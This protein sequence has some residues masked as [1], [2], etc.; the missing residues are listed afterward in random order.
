[1]QGQMNRS[2]NGVSNDRVE[3]NYWVGD[4]VIG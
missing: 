3:L 1:M 2:R 4:W